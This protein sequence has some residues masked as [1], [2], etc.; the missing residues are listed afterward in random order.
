MHSISLHCRRLR[1]LK[2]RSNN[3]SIVWKTFI[4]IFGCSS[5]KKIIIGSVC[6]WRSKTIWIPVEELTF[7]KDIPFI[8]IPWSELTQRHWPCCCST[9]ITKTT[10][11]HA[12]TTATTNAVCFFMRRSNRY[13][14]FRI[15]CSSCFW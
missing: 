10:Y 5:C 7:W 2:R 9:T 8:L 6:C 1:S 12:F 14:R 15:S 4:I 11:E 3:V 13:C